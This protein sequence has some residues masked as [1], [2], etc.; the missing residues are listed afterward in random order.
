MVVGCRAQFC[1]CGVIMQI[2]SQYDESLF[3]RDSINSKVLMITNLAT[4]K[5]MYEVD[6]VV[7]VK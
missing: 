7:I 5:C 1:C 3:L 4:N 6:A 2:Q